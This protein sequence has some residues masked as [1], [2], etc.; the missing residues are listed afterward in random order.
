MDAQE[1]LSALIPDPTTIVEL[2]ERVVEGMWPRSDSDRRALFHKLGFTSGARW[3]D[4]GDDSS[5]AH[6]A[7]LTELPGVLSSSWT[8]YNGHFM[9]VSMQPYTDMAPNNPGTRTGY[10]AISAQLTELYGPAINPW[11]DPAVQTCI[12]NVNGRRIIIRFFN[13]QHS[14]IM[15]SVYDA[16]LAAAADAESRHHTAP[17]HWNGSEERVSPFVL[18]RLGSGI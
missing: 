8:S 11:H 1:Q 3:D 18:P 6:F 14:G 4:P 5:T 17:A 2:V 15:L 7:L 16:G 10:E 9:G 12:W 13:L